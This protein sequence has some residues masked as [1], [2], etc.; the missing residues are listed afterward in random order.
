MEQCQSRDGTFIAY[1]PSGTGTPLVLVHGTSVDHTNFAPILPALEQHFRLYTVERRGRGQSGDATPYTLEREGEDIAAVVDSI[2][3]SVDVLGYSFGCLCALEAAL[4]TTNIRRLI[5]F[6]PP[7]PNGLDWWPEA[8]GKRIHALLEAEEHEQTLIAFFKELLR[9][10]PHELADRQARSTWPS[11]V[12]MVPTIPRELES[13]GRYQCSPD[14]FHSMVCPTML[15]RGGA[16]PS[17]RRT[18]VETLHAALPTSHIVVLPGQEHNAMYTAPDL[19]TQEVVQFL[20]ASA[21][22]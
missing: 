20:T 11:R 4:L 19:F 8:F 3:G 1:Q 21:S 6:E 13:I 14:R 5:L 7:L 22:S 18:M 10:S 2:G 12:A 17:W 9:E 15:L 16:S